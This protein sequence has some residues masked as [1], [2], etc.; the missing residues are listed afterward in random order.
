MQHDIFGFPQEHTASELTVSP[1]PPCLLI[2]G[3]GGW[4]RCPM[5]HQP[6]IRFVDSHPEGAGGN[7]DVH[8]I[9]EKVLQR[10]APPELAQPR[11][12]GYGSVAGP[13][14]GAGDPLGRS[15]RGRIHDGELVLAPQQIEQ[16]L[17][18]LPLATHAHSTQPEIA[19]V[20][21]AEMKP[22][23]TTKSER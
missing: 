12:I 8:A 15:A 7:D 16:C 4:W 1:C 3:L 10:C 6:D 14:E 18:S 20:E 9:L 2:V 19:A 23:A 13:G 21:R 17:H 22:I 11:M 5:H